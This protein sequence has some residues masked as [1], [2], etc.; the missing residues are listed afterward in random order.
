[1]RVLDP[2]EHSISGT[3]KNGGVG[4]RRE[5]VSL[6]LIPIE[7]R[8][9]ETTLYRTLVQNVWTC[10]VDSRELCKVSE[11]EGGMSPI[12]PGFEHKED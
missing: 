4:L 9:E 10:S 7:V 11:Q 2:E 1:M 5:G 12:H 6:R 8:G 3:W